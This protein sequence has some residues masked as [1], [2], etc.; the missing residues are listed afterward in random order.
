MTRHATRWAEHGPDT[1]AVA[2]LAIA[3]LVG[4]Q[5]TIGLYQGE[6]LGQTETDLAYE[7]ITDPPGLKFWPEN[8]GRD[9]CRTPMVWERAAPNGGFSA[10][11]PWLPVKPP[12]LARA[13]DA[14][15]GAPGSVLAAYRA[16]LAF[17]RAEPALRDGATVFLEVAAPVLAFRRVLGDRAIT[18]VYNLSPQPV[19][20]PLPAPGTAT[21]PGEGC[22]WAEGALRLGPAGYGFF[23]GPGVPEPAVG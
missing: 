5:G 7:E 23:T 15:A 3:M 13:V 21:G 1:D 2:R 12:Q 16:A 9:G 18:C 19:A 20:L 17:R 22:D 4:F 6:E 8:K 14:Q 10:A 11:R